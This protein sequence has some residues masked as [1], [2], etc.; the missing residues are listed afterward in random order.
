MRKNCSLIFRKSRRASNSVDASLK[1]RR[2]AKK[3]ESQKVGASI[4][5]SFIF[6][7]LTYAG[8][9]A[10]IFKLRNLIISQKLCYCQRQF[11]LNNFLF[12]VASSLNLISIIIFYF[13]FVKVF[14]LTLKVVI[15]FL[16][17]AQNHRLFAI[18][19]FFVS[20]FIVF[21]SLE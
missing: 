2:R 16:L 3:N 6:T 4:F 18:R 10:K 12:A 11:S 8:S 17:I 1:N 9:F 13:F 21:L 20:A 14:C 15:D 5:I 19:V 7:M